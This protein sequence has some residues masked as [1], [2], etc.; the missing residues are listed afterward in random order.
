MLEPLQHLSLLLEALLLC[1]GQLTVLK[2]R[3]RMSVLKT[4]K[5]LS[6]HTVH[7]DTYTVCVCVCVCLIA[8]STETRI[9]GMTGKLT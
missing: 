9:D 1:F 7:A 6:V 3:E 8:Y 4:L 5:A 2:G